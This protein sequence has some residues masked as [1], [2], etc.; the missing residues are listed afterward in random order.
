MQDYE[1][2]GSFYLGR[3]YDLEAGRTR[4]DLLLYDSKD[5]CT[6]A[7]CVGMTGSGKTGLGVTLLEEAAIDGIP[8]IVIDPKGDLGNLML[9]FPRLRA[10]D[11]RPWVDPG[12]ATRKGLTADEFAEQT[13][14]NWKQG[15]ADWD[16]DGERIERLRNAA[17]VA[18]YTPGSRTGRPL[19]VLRSFDAPSAEFRADGELFRQRIASAASGLLALLGIVGDTLQ[20]REHILVARILEE[21]WSAGRNLD[22]A[23]LLRE[24]QSPPFDR[25]GF[26]DL[27]SFFP[28]GDR[29]ELAMR[30]NNLLASPGFASWLEGEPLDVRRLLYTEA[31]RPRVSVLSIAHL[32]DAERMFFVTILLEEIVAWMRT[33]PGT[34]SLRAILYMD[35]IFG[36]FPPTANPPSK[37][38]M[39]TLLK[40]ARAY[41]LGCV[42]A[43]QN[44]VDLDYKGL[45]NCGTWFLGRLQT[46][47][48]KLRVLDGLETAATTTGRGFD[49]KELEGVL[50]SLAGR[51]FLMNNVHDAGPVVFHTR[52]AMSYLRGPMTREQIRS[53]TA[54]RPA[55]DA[56]PGTL[57]AAAADRVAVEPAGN[58]AASPSATARPIV[59][60]DVPEAFLAAKPGS[61][62]R[63]VYRPALFAVAKLHYARSTWDLDCWRTV[64]VQA[65]ADAVEAGG[66]PWDA[67][68]VV[69][70]KE[71]PE[72]DAKPHEGAIF[73]DVPGAWLNAANHKKWRTVLRDHLYRSQTLTLRKSARPKLISAADESEADFRARLSQGARELRDLEVEKLRRSYGS[74]LETLE[75]RI[76][77]ATQRVDRE[78]SQANQSTF[79]AALHF[80]S[81]MLGALFGR[82][83]FSSTN[84]SKTATSMR[85]AGRAAEQ[86]EDVGRAEEDVRDLEE[87][88]ADLE[89][90]FEQEAARVR[91]AFALE[92]LELETLE[93]KP[94]KSDVEV[95]EVRLLWTPWRVDATGIA[96]PA[97]A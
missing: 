74:K 1:Q 81:T 16:Q 45:S 86:R 87:E 31:G 12:E 54:D 52:W 96:S 90:E 53:L 73:G 85:S 43:T 75:D 7:V 93:V 71:E 36:Y 80:G 50:S 19:T 94:R 47:R 58:V 25:V 27:E 8:A 17:E 76:R 97:F 24:I 65:L 18:I 55:S 60:P 92:N 13:A 37:T 5:L 89:R 29:F 77:R 56:A 35:E 67:A 9:T 22:V 49:R 91:E 11:F 68:A 61:D 32:S 44:P 72:F 4:P 66:S 70:A 21:A 78:R 10:E 95:G 15:L 84:V 42:L 20:S 59:P 38:P 30:L 62:G 48:D 79:S 34:S 83:T 6:H 40:Q 63:L 69:L 2:L 82:K 26:L 51:V 39:L 64:H 28:K 14:A 23:A 33:Q 46:E 88:F 3:L 41:G 57:A